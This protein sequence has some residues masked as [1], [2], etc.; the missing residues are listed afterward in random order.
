MISANRDYKIVLN[1][2]VVIL[3]KVIFI[4]FELLSSF[5]LG[6]L[7]YKHMIMLY[8]ILFK[9]VET[10]FLISGTVKRF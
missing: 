9:N 4:A 7:L 6:E 5:L 3:Y 8:R 10:V 1:D 2:C